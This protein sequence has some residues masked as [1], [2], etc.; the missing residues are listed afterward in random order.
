MNY[1]KNELTYKIY[2]KLNL[3][4]PINVLN[5][6]GISNV[7]ST[8]EYN[9][10]NLEEKIYACDIGP[11]NCLIDYVMSKRLNKPFDN[12]GIE[13]SKGEVQQVFFQKL[14]NSC[15]SLVKEP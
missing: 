1:T 15:K 10:L 4:F 11:G 14:I 5:I 2:K 3:D 12:K 13:A 7:T 6:G 8:I 9:N